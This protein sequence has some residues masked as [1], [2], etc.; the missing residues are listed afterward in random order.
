[1]AVSYIRHHDRR[2]RRRRRPRRTGGPA[3]APM[4][5]HRRLTA[6]VLF[7]AA[8]AV[9]C[10]TQSGNAPIPSTP[11]TAAPSSTQPTSPLVSAPGVAWAVVRPTGGDDTA[12]LQAAVDR[13]D[14]IVI[15]GT[16][17]IAGVVHIGR[18]V[19][20]RWRS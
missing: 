10:A 16:L 18:P 19:E 20:I 1:M 4:S 12:A 17:H 14:H 13:F 11:V 6:A 8:V 5:R 3:E 9:G 15:I 7:G 2:P